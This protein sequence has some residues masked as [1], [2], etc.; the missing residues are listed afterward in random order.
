VQSH[1][2]AHPPDGALVHP[3]ATAARPSARSSTQLSIDL[4]A[5]FKET[6]LY[7]IDHYLGK[8]MVQN[9]QVR[10]VRRAGRCCRTCR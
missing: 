10:A 4:G 5:L 8:E 3:A 6:E 9:L 7:R 1:A 2:P